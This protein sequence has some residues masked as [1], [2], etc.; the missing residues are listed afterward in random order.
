M[1]GHGRGKENPRVPLGV[2]AQ[3]Q[4]RDRRPR[5]LPT[6]NSHA[7]FWSRQNKTREY[8]VDQPSITP[9][10]P[11]ALSASPARPP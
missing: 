2:R 8:Q 10:P 7:V 5:Q 3:T 9:C 1:G 11:I 6:D 4:T